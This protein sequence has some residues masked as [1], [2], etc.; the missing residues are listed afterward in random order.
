M[1]EESQFIERRKLFEELNT[2]MGFSAPL[3]GLLMA[4]TNKWQLDILKLDEKLSAHLVDYDP[5]ECTYKGKENMSI[6]KVMLEAFGQRSVDI[7][8]EL[9]STID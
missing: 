4:A 1:T 3:D 8:N 7:V 9:L 5:R 2:L 6:S